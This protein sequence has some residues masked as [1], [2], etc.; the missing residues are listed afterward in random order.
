M[1]DDISLRRM[2]ID[3]WLARATARRP[4][5]VA[6]E[7]PEGRLTYREL[8]M[9]ATRGAAR[10]VSR[11]AAPGDRVAITLPPGRAFVVAFHGCLLLR[12]PAMPVDPRLRERERKDLLRGAEFLVNTP[13]AEDGGA[14]F[15]V[16]EPHRDEI[17]L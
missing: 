7:A 15:N 4:D 3:P 10:L 1:A 13:L 2:E 17:A 14:P 16:V 12:S 8:L 9:A 6:P 11:G 5:T